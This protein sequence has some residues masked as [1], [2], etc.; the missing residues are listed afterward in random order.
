MNEDTKYLERLGLFGKWNALAEEFVAH[1]Y[2][3]ETT[4]SYYEHLKK[5]LRA[6]FPYVF[7]CNR[8][9]TRQAFDQVCK[10]A[11]W[12]IMRNRSNVL[13][14]LIDF[15]QWAGLWFREQ[16]AY[17]LFCEPCVMRNEYCAHSTE[18]LSVTSVMLLH[19]KD[20]DR[21]LPGFFDA[22]GWQEE[23]QT[24]MLRAWM[25]GDLGGPEKLFG[26][27]LD[28][29][30]HAPWEPMLVVLQEI[31]DQH[32]EIKM[33][34][35]EIVA[36]RSNWSGIHI[37]DLL[38]YLQKI[39]TPQTPLN[40]RL[41]EIILCYPGLTPKDY[42]K[43][44]SDASKGLRRDK[45]YIDLT[46]PSRSVIDTLR[47]RLEDYLKDD[48]D[49]TDSSDT[50]KHGVV[51]CFIHVVTKTWL[52]LVLHDHTGSLELNAGDILKIREDFGGLPKLK[53]S[54]DAAALAQMSVPENLQSLRPKLIGWESEPKSD[55][56]REGME[57]ESEQAGENQPRTI[58]GDRE[59]SEE[60]DVQ[61]ISSDEDE[62]E[63]IPDHQTP[64]NADQ[65]AHEVQY[66]RG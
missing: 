31:P 17:D 55:P 4:A 13:L 58:D 11:F 8:G 39:R 5:S 37:E 50:E 47:T 20:Q 25:S 16:E 10:K 19:T 2:N 3:D 9:R 53:L 59:R 29:G 56:S 40:W 36:A 63:D 27:W 42:L 33:R 66:A 60:V 12:D 41:A 30:I 38:E 44:L 51:S 15:I 26:A 32:A 45:G 18:C 43:R 48:W 14:A 61:V 22:L 23:S 46:K 1:D 6:N 34:A 62:D 28:N 54:V 65:H 35:T 21:D 24:L 57:V 52:D 7:Y 49:W 64:S